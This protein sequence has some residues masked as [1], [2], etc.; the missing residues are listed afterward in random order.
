M[1]STHFAFSSRKYFYY[2]FSLFPPP[3][4]RNRHLIFDYLLLLNFFI[5]GFF[6]LGTLLFDNAFMDFCSV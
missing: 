3:L 2:F 1:Y 6:F 5:P 4:S